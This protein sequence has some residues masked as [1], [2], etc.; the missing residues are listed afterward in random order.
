MLPGVLLQQAEQSLSMA[1]GGI[2]SGGSYGIGIEN[3]GTLVSTSNGAINLRGTSGPSNQEGIL[4]NTNGVVT[5]TVSAPITLRALSDILIQTS[6]SVSAQGLGDVSL[7]A[8][9]SIRLE[10]TSIVTANTGNLTL[11]VDNR[12][13]TPPG[14]GLGAFILNAGATL[15]AGGQ[16]CIYTARRSQNIINE[17]VNGVPFIPGAFNVNTLIETW[18][19]YFPNGGYGGLAFNFYYKEGTPVLGPVYFNNVAANLVQLPALLPIIKPPRIP[20]YFP[21]YHF[22]VCEGKVCAPTLSPYGSFI[23]EDALWWI[24]LDR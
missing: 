12:F 5:T 4:I 2:G 10:T 17:L 8:D 3:T 6:G 24:G 18:A 22:Q 7:I 11:I 19:A 13:P 16:L 14:M 1:R 15:T 23:F 21:N 20:L 9:N